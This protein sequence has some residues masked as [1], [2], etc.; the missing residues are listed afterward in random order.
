MIRIASFGK[1][2]GP[3]NVLR[4]IDLHVPT[5]SSLVI[6]GQSGCGKS[7]LLRHVAGIENDVSGGVE[8]TIEIEGIGDIT[9]LAERTL[10]RKRIRGLEIGFLF[11]EGA[12]FDFCDIEE[13]LGWPLAVHTDLEPE[14]VARRIA[15]ALEFVEMA[16]VP[17]IL[18][19]KP[20]GLSGGQKKRIALARALVL[21]P[22]IMLY[23]EPTAGLDPP[24]AAGISNLIRRLQ[25]ERGLTSI[26]STHDMACARTIADQVAFLSGGRIL[27]RGTFDEA[28]EDPAVQG[29]MQGDL[30]RVEKQLQP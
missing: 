15:E 5:G 29:F 27:F 24:I 26:T 2:Y 14:G 12:L 16:K 3:V 18:A 1:S 13:N 30:P 11:Q 17:G 8:G 4:E 20:S 7:T 28:L 10:S 23:D 6:I 25:Q 9:A 21:Q 22:R 19:K